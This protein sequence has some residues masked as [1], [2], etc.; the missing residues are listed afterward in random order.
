[1][2]DADHFRFIHDLYEFNDE[3]LASNLYYK[4]SNLKSYAVRPRKRDM[5]VE[6]L[7]FSLMPNHFHLLLRQLK[8]KGISRFM[9]RLNG[10]YTWYF[11]N[12]YQRVGPLFQGRFGAAFVGEESYLMHLPIYIHLNPLDL[13]NKKWRSHGVIYVD[14]ALRGLESYRWSSHLDYLGKKNFPSVTSRDFMLQVFGGRDAY[15]EAIRNWISDP[16][17]QLLED[18]HLSLCR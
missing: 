18:A 8:E 4:K 15:I 14:E 5:L 16:K 17:F 9:H 3:E 11:N 2:D 10:G 6:V 1:M 7:S 12:R 13:T